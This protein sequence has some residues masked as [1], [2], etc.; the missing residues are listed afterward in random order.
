MVAGLVVSLLVVICC[1]V[2]LD[3]SPIPVEMFYQTRPTRPRRTETE[4][5][6]QRRKREL[7]RDAGVP[8]LRRNDVCA[9][10]PAEKI[11]RTLRLSC[12]RV[13]RARAKKR[14]EKLKASA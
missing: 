7:C 2:P 3:R 1:V 13:R 6:E 4:G 11:D 9:L 8:Y 14:A 12:A 5:E 10:D